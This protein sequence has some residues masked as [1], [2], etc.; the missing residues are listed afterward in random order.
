VSLGRNGVVENSKAR[1]GIRVPSRSASLYERHLE[2]PLRARNGVKTSPAQI[3]F[4][5]TRAQIIRAPYEV[6]EAL[7]LRAD[8][9]S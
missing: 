3:Q 6:A 8:V 4:G 2:D 5:P 7:L 1:A 9:P